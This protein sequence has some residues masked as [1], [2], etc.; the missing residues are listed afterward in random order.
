MNNI[1]VLL[2]APGCG[3]GT[4]S[5]HILKKYDFGYLSLGDALR[6]KKDTDL[7]LQEKLKQG[8]LIDSEYI[9]NVL[10]KEISILQ[11][12]II[13][14]DG[15]PRKLDQA[16]YLENKYNVFVIYFEIDYKLLKDRI[17][18]RYT[19]LDCKEQGYMKNA[20]PNCKSS[21]I[22]K[23]ADDNEETLLKR[24]NEYEN[25]TLEVVSYYKNKLAKDKLFIIKADQ[26]TSEEIFNSQTLPII[27]SILK[28]IS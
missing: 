2:G 17:I 20:C 14:L 25:N 10:N 9:N 13:L 21:N 12:D 7:D 28:Q 6:A 19:C 5:K 26:G 23:R 15:Y 11:N 18:N 4:Q 24:L 22:V 27:L 8:M 16:L 3:K 1:I